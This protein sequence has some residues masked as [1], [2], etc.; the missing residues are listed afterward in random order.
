V[1]PRLLWHVEAGGWNL[2]GFEH[3]DA[4][5]A[6]LTPGSTDIPKVLEAVGALA[7]VDLPALPLRRITDRWAEHGHGVSL[8]LL[9][10]DTL[11]HTDLNPN[12]LLINHRAH[13]VDWAW[14]TRGAAWIDSGCLALWLIANGHTPAQAEL[15]VNLP[16][17]NTTSRLQWTPSSPSAPGS[18]MTSPAISRED[19]RAAWLR[20]RRNGQHTD[21]DTRREPPLVRGL[22]LRH[23]RSSTRRVSNTCSSV[24]WAISWL[25]VERRRTGMFK[26]TCQPISI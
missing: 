3:I 21:P 26:G 5:A 10:G 16:A 7:Q 25:A 1:S 20:R 4:R 23:P 24:T 15:V 6:D 8:D 18:G 17:R 19:G 9:D 12:N 14:P 22:R 2:L 13:I 11:L